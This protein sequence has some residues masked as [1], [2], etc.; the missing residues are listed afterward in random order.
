MSKSI[1]QTGRM[2]TVDTEQK[3]YK[4]IGFHYILIAMAI[5]FDDTLC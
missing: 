3:H 2:F 4:G 5:T 1:H